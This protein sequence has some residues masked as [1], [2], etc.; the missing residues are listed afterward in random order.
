M[1]VC[2]Q[3]DI[4]CLQTQLVYVQVQFVCLHMFIGTALNTNL[5]CL[6]GCRDASTMFG[7]AACSMRRSSMPPATSCSASSSIVN[8]KIALGLGHDMEGQQIQWLDF[9]NERQGTRSTLTESSQPRPK[10]STKSAITS[11]ASTSNFLWPKRMVRPRRSLNQPP[12][13]H[14][15]KATEGLEDWVKRQMPVKHLGSISS[16]SDL[17]VATLSTTV[18]EINVKDEDNTRV[19]LF[20]YVSGNV[21][22]KFNLTFVDPRTVTTRTTAATAASGEILYLFQSDF[23]DPH[24]TAVS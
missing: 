8:I 5:L 24:S 9:R 3:T 1:L 4:I 21:S 18:L 19:N 2:L 6:R 22:T 20:V 10:T 11:T 23:M 13:S 15:V 7:W 17:F 14:R 12:E 16:G